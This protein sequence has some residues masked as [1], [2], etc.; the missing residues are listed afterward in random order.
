[1]DFYN[2]DLPD[3]VLSSLFYRGQTEDDFRKAAEEADW[4]HMQGELHIRHVERR[5]YCV[6]Y[7]ESEEYQIER[8]VYARIVETVKPYLGNILDDYQPFEIVFEK[9]TIEVSLLFDDDYQDR[10][11]RIHDEYPECR[12]TGSYS[13][14]N[15]IVEKRIETSFLS[16]L[17]DR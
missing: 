13:E 15:K 7:L 14:I 16:V 11:D 9:D 2:C 1:M 8:E 5:Q 4:L 6:E 10:Y 3:S 12:E 17:N